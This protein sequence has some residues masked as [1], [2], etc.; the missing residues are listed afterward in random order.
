MDI[1]TG[2]VANTE[3]QRSTCRRIRLQSNKKASWH[4][5]DAK[6]RTQNDSINF[7]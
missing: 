1:V 2:Q 5:T 7:I 4:A 3:L 6:R